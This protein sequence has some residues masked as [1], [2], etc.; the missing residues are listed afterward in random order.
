MEMKYIFETSSTSLFSQIRSKIR[1]P[2]TVSKVPH[3]SFIKKS[4]T[5]FVS[6]FRYSILRNCTREYFA[7]KQAR[8]PL[9]LKLCKRIS[10]SGK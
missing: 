2:I 5:D 3:S 6:S 8:L 1:G 4:Y 7:R 9:V 10:D